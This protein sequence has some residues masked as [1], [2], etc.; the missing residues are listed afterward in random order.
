M[1]TETPSHIESKFS[2]QDKSRVTSSHET[3]SLGKRLF[4]LLVATF[5]LNPQLTRSAITLPPI[6]PKPPV[7]KINTNYSIVSMGH[8]Q[9][10][11]ILPGIS[12]LLAYP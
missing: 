8:D 12:Y 3:N 2:I 10:P 4:F 6:K 9:T 1:I 11:I 5:T 7:T